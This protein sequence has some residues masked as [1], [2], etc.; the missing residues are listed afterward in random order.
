VL[1][2]DI[3]MTGAAGALARVLLLVAWFAAAA[4]AAGLRGRRSAALLFG[5]PLAGF[6]IGGVGSAAVVP[7]VAAVGAMLGLAVGM[8]AATLVLGWGQEPG[9]P[10]YLAL[11]LT[12]CA[13]AATVEAAFGI[14]TVAPD[15]ILWVL[16]GVAAALAAG[17]G[18]GYEEPRLPE[19]SP[20]AS[21]ATSR[22][23]DG[24]VTIRWSSG[25]A[26][27]GTAFGVAAFLPVFAL[28][29]NAPGA[30]PEDAAP[31]AVLAAILALAAASL[32]AGAACVSATIAGGV[33]TAVLALVLVLR[34]VTLG[35]ADASALFMV[36][37]WT[38][39]ALAL[40]AGWW[41]RTSIPARAPATRGVWF[42][43]YALPAVVAVAVIQ[44][45]GIRPVHADI[46][47][48]RAYQDMATALQTDDSARFAQGQALFD[49]VALMAPN[50]PSYF[51]NWG[52]LYAVAAERSQGQVEGAAAAF[53]KAQEYA[54][55]AEA[56][57]PR[58]PYHAYNRGHVQLLFAN[59]L[60]PET[61]GPVA[62]NAADALQTAFNGAPTDT[63][64]AQE[65]ATARLMAGDLAK[66][67][68]M[69]DYVLTLSPN[70]AVAHIALGRIH[71][72]AGDLAAAAQAYE[73]AIEFEKTPLAEPRLA[74]GEL[75]RREDR[76]SDA[77][78]WYA[79]AAEVSPDDWAVAYNLGLL[80]RDLG[81][82]NQAMTEL[83][84]AIGLA[85]AEEQ[86]RIQDALDSVIRGGG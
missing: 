53:A 17:S 37:V 20:A 72:A 56:A 74:L 10:R 73:K 76:L 26:G 22:S 29:A 23:D 79:Q 68:E 15:T 43:A 41:L 54:G 52:E 80:Y 63:R 5:L 14:R 8:L 69:I 24:A 59:M 33:A 28:L 85:P 4:R 65:L 83:S 66:A 45:A 70:D 21:P 84:R 30:R 38:L 58:L 25:G 16:V 81:D 18:G 82:T 46:L 19:Q 32:A 2:D 47:F 60:P 34:A 48:Q 55:R 40:I 35:A 49:R 71:E 6:V 44:M 31:V 78:S 39:V 50:E 77:L 67:R 13:A 75:A 42:M 7:A 11:G 3:V 86:Q 9:E 51:L 27:L 61:R 57:E 64:I 1:L 62:A 12:A 36:L